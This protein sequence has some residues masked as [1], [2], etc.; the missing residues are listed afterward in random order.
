MPR[1]SKHPDRSV[2]FAK[3]VSLLWPLLV[4]GILAFSILVPIAPHIQLTPSTDSSVFLYVGDRILEGAIP[5]KDVWDHKGPLIY[6]IDALGL[7]MSSGS[8]WGV[9]LLE[10]VAVLIAAW[11]GYGLMKRAFGTWP[12]I[13]AVILFLLELRLVLDLGNLTEEFALPFQV[14]LLWLFWRGT[15]TKQVL[16]YFL[17]GVGAAL[18]FLLRPNIIGIPLAI[19]ITIGWQAFAERRKEAWKH[20][21]IMAAGGFSILGLVAIYFF[22]AQALPQLWDAVFAF[23]FA[24]DAEE[25]GNQIDPLL[26]GFANLPLSTIFG[27][28][29]WVLAIAAL[30]SKL[31][32]SWPIRNLVF[33][34]S[35]GVPLEMILTSLTGNDF[36]HYYMS[37]LPLLALSSC[38]FVYFISTNISPS[39]KG[40]S[41]HGHLTQLIVL[42]LIITISITP[43]MGLQPTVES[44]LV[45]A[46]KAGGLPS[47]DLR[48]HQYESVLNYVFK[49]MAA[50]QPLL[51]WGNQVTIN[52]LTD[53][54]APTRFVYQTP[55]FVEGY[56]SLTKISE[57]LSALEVNP[58][59][60][61]DTGAF[62]PSIDAVVDQL[63]NDLKPLY[64]YLQEN[65]VYS[66]TFRPTGWDLYLYQ[67][68]GVPLEQ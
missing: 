61:I 8:R 50:D 28:T 64:L 58:G 32:L 46:L 54:N 56:A 18:C 15:N 55:L 6:Y 43:V 57:L 51:V 21:G 19:G 37:W 10:F 45:A 33:L 34:V 38:F 25:Q 9:W 48:G 1:Q 2:S 53:H 44:S 42:P 67:G 47:V 24:Y 68:Q 52:W 36:P 41:G 3:R 49:N 39:V 40:W 31:R 4:L 7:A 23:N 29:G 35:I 16:Y 30:R 59:V 66:G 65:Y 5:Y 12:A 27:V 60:I 20:L 14:A 62:I 63:P 26:S 11:V 22:F 17:I 13:F